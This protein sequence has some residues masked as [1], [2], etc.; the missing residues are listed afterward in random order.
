MPKATWSEVATE[1][2]V[3]G[4][5][6]GTDEEEDGV[7][8]R[9]LTTNHLQRILCRL[10]DN[11]LLRKHVQ[12]LSECNAYDDMDRLTELRH[13]HTNHDWVTTVDPE[14]GTILNGDDYRLAL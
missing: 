10:L 2:E 9:T 14:F 6:E 13:P 4:D 12:N 8:T 11:T 5:P 1:L 7:K 3:L